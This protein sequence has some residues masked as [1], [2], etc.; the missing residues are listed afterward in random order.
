M[1]LTP[2]E[3]LEGY[4]V[5][6]NYG[7]RVQVFVDPTIPPGTDY[8]NGPGDI[9][10]SDGRE[11]IVLQDVNGGFLVASN[12]R[13]PFI[14]VREGP[15][16]AVG[17]GVTDDRVAIGNAYAAAAILGKNLFIPAG[18]YYVSYG[19]TTFTPPG[20]GSVIRAFDIRSNVRVFGEKGTV[21]YAPDPTPDVTVFGAPFHTVFGNDGSAHN[22]AIEDIEFDGGFDP[23]PPGIVEQVHGPIYVGPCKDFSIQRLECYGWRG[24]VIHGMCNWDG[25]SILDWVERFKLK[26]I[27]IHDCLGVGIDFTRGARDFWCQDNV[28]KDELVIA[29]SESIWFGN[30]SFEPLKA[31]RGTITGNRV[32]R[33]GAMA[34]ENLDDCTVDDNHVIWP[35]GNPC[36]RMGELSFS[37]VTNNTGDGDSPEADA[38][39]RGISCNFHSRFNDNVFADNTF[40]RKA[41]ANSSAAIRISGD[42]I[43]GERITLH[44]NTVD[45]NGALA[46]G[47]SNGSIHVD[48]VTRLTLNDNTCDEHINLDATVNWSTIEGNTASYIIAGCS[49]STVGPNTCVTTAGPALWAA[50]NRN[51]IYVGRLTGVP[52]FGEGVLRVDGSDNSLIGGLVEDTRTIVNQAM[53]SEHGTAANNTY[54][55]VKLLG[56]QAGAANAVVIVGSS[57]YVL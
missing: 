36:F 1:A 25:A 56:P 10:D 23:A 24:G 50:G 20:L 49:D 9:A 14:N 5:H 18:R 48:H 33:Y 38:D 35:T 42:T 3:K 8:I 28:V 55:G 32:T 43:Q 34:L 22:F 17:D 27:N 53:I 30:G 13:A 26:D 12:V 54:R 40:K 46:F 51:A 47:G 15:Y 19:A 21:I 44:D 45:D 16:N 6:D 39:G 57:S 4:R 31:L 41:K 7:R 37:H 29:G 52:A 2:N 11:Q